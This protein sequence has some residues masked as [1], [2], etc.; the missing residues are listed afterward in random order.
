MHI[1]S[2]R[3]V[4]WASLIISV[5][6]CRAALQLEVSD[7]QTVLAGATPFWTESVLSRSVRRAD[8]D[9]RTR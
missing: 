9:L 2:R 4:L 3:S 7:H 8:A 1:P 5:A 6:G